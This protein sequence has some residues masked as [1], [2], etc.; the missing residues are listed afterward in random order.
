MTR[1]R[2]LGEISYDVDEVI[3]GIVGSF[4]TKV[5]SIRALALGAPS[6]PTVDDIV[7]EY[8]KDFASALAKGVGL[9]A[10]G[11]EDENAM[12]LPAAGIIEPNA[13]HVVA[14]ITGGGSGIGRA[15]AVRLA[16]GG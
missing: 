2:K 8:C 13:N 14:L 7:Q 4:P 10:R 16:R 12:P 15:T 6:M 3:S 5:D 1:V 9:R 11:G